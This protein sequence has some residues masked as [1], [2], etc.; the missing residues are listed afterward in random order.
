MDYLVLSRSLI[1]VFMLYVLK[2]K[3]MLLE[4]LSVM[5]TTLEA[6][7]NDCESKSSDK[8]K[9]KKKMEKHIS[10]TIV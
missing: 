1:T 7:P 8:T 6:W 9:T 2:K 10:S 4:S 5:I 3:T